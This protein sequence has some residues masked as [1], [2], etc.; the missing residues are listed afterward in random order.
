MFADW[1][2]GL[3]V[4]AADD[5]I[6]DNELTV[7]ENV[8]LGLRGG[9]SKRR[10]T[11][12]LNTVSY[13]AKVS[14]LLEWPRM[15]GGTTL[16]AVI[17][18]ALCEIG[19]DTYT[20]TLI[21]DVAADHIGHVFYKNSV[22]FVDG[23]GFYRYDG[24]NV[25]DVPARTTRPADTDIEPWG[26]WGQLPEIGEPVRMVTPE[27]VIITAV[28]GKA[29]EPE[30]KTLHLADLAGGA[31]A[32]IVVNKTTFRFMDEDSPN[33]DLFMMV[34]GVDEAYATVTLDY[35]S[36]T[37]IPV[38]NDLTP[39]RRCRFLVMNPKSGR[40]FAAGDPHY[41]STMYFSETHDPTWWK[42]TSMM[43][44]T[45]AD[46]PI[47]GLALFGDAVLVFFP[48]AIWAWRGLDP[49]V[50][51]VWERLS[52][53]QGTLAPD[54]LA[55]TS[56]S[57]TYLSTGG[58]FSISPS[59]LSMT[60]AVMPGDELVANLCRYKTTNIINSITNPAIA[61]GVWDNA[62][63]RYLLSYSDLADGSKNNKVLVYDWTLKA[64]M[65]WTG[66]EVW[67]WLCRLDGTLL[68]GT[69]DG[70]I[71]KVGE[72]SADYLGQPISMTAET[73]PFSFEVPTL[74]KRFWGLHADYKQDETARGELTAK[75]KVDGAVTDTFTNPKGRQRTSR[76]GHRASV[77]VENSTTE[78]CHVMTIGIPYTVASEARTTY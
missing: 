5:L 3:N 25:E 59:M 55:L 78:P 77:R 36:E 41:P 43:V 16:F 26:G 58:V 29:P 71:I 37:E 6:G 11:Q 51:A 76:F 24:T 15:S 63:Q 64:F 67:G 31:M 44:P 53:S 28:V 38:Q 20:K 70:Y 54:S 34:V 60:V 65:Q 33:S 68:A 17:G 32:D 8:E 62:G 69:H 23:N 47:T 18:Q 4:D 52:T 50:D 40:M 12:K 35:K 45:N 9:I 13:G 74:K 7:A 10:G 42:P 19:Q 61:S 75:L 14:Q 46:G 56:N 30:T 73:K 48:N 1:R 57:L 66:L 49:E 2:G 39:I 21:R 27:G 22:Y 72:G